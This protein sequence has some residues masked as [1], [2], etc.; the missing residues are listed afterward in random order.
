MGFLEGNLR[1]YLNRY[2]SYLFITQSFTFWQHKKL[3]EWALAEVLK[4]KIL[5]GLTACER[6]DLQQ[7]TKHDFVYRPDY[8][9]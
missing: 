4:K 8:S 7:F 9:S 1:I 5:K 6:N 2:I 3:Y